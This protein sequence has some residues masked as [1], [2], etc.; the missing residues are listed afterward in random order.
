MKPW[1]F[2]VLLV[3]FNAAP[4]L[5]QTPASETDVH[6]IKL[7]K[8]NPSDMQVTCTTERSIG[9]MIP[10]RVCR[11]KAQQRQDRESSQAALEQIRRSSSIK[12]RSAER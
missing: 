3:A 1:Q 4:A 12:V 5:A 10:S 8:V 11:T 2:A 6:P 9:S 7:G